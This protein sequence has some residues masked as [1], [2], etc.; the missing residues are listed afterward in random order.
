[1]RQI[2]LG[3]AMVQ[4]LFFEVTQVDAADIHGVAPRVI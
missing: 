2:I 4:V 3:A 1:M